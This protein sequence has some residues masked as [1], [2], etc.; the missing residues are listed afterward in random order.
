MP[1]LQARRLT[2]RFGG[3]VAVNRLDLT[4][5]PGEV[6]G[7]IGPNGAGKTTL[8]SLLTGFL[9]PDSGSILFDGI[10]V[11]GRPPHRICRL[12]MVRTF[13][14]LKP[15]PRLTIR[16]NI[17]VGALACTRDRDLAAKNADESMDLLGLS[18]MSNQLPDEL[19]IGHLKMVEVARAL[20][21]KPRLLLLDEP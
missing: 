8:F 17:M 5:E 14:N 15:F 13:Q 10:D 21:T 3:L 6:L 11:S 18:P 16:Q 1:L 4:T 9:K 12:G 19:S 20:A 2:R 7:V